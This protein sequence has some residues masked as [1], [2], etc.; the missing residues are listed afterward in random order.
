MSKLEKVEVFLIACAAGLAFVLANAGV[1]PAK[2]KTSTLILVLSN[3]ILVQGLVR[4]LALIY[5]YRSKEKKQPSVSAS[6]ICAESTVGVTGI[7]IGA[8][9]M[10]YASS[11]N[12]GI[13]LDPLA[14]MATSL[15]TMFAGYF[16][17]DWVFTWNPV[18]I[19]YDKN[20]VNIVVKWK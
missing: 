12:P 17:K 16:I 6:C 19:K 1:V 2:I 4:D 13:S 9:I 3:I 8:T 5:L 10:L 18:G 14:W 7:I 15:A 11:Y 20:H